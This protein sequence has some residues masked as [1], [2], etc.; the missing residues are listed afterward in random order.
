MSF[1][2]SLRRDK[3]T[4]GCASK[5]GRKSSTRNEIDAKEGGGTKNTSGKRVGRHERES[6]PHECANVQQTVCGIKFFFFP[7]QNFCWLLHLFFLCLST[8]SIRRPTVPVSAT[9]FLSTVVVY[10]LLAHKFYTGHNM[11]HIVH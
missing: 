4:N 1:L 11:S 2:F 9:L 10:E 3:Q 7:V 6:G 5:M 8:L